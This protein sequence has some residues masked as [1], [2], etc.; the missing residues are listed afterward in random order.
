VEDE[1]ENEYLTVQEAS[2]LLN[3]SPADLRRILRAHG[4]GPALRAAAGRQ[5]LIRRQDLEALRKPER[6]PRRRRGVA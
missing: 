4:L 1:T 6:Q 5:V 3:V 2:E